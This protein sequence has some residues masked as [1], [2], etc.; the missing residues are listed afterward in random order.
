MHAAFIVVAI[1]QLHKSLIFG[2]MGA[3][4]LHYIG[5]FSL[6]LVSMDLW[7]LGRATWYIIT[8]LWV[9]FHFIA[10]IVVL[11]Y[12]QFGDLT[13]LG[14]HISGRARYPECDAIYKKPLFALSGLTRR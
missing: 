13:G 11:A 12:F 6:F 5:N 10:M 4:R 3:M 7:N 8:I 9:Q 1:R 14:F 2:I